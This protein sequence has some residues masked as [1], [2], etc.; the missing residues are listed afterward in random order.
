M[1]TTIKR[2]GPALGLLLAA[3]MAPPAAAEPALQV[4]LWPESPAPGIAFRVLARGEWPSGC[5]PPV[6]DSWV[7]GREIVL[8]LRPTPKDCAKGP[9]LP[10]EIYN[11]AAGESRL[12]V[13]QEGVYRLRVIG[14]E[15]ERTLAFALAQIGDSPRDPRPETGLWWPEQAGEFAEGG[16]GLGA[17]VEVQGQQVAITA[18]GYEG[19]GQPSWWIGASRL[20]GAL[21]RLALSHLKG[22]AGPFQRYRRP[23]AVEPVGSLFVEWL[24]SARAVFWFVAEGDG[25]QGLQVQPISMVRFSFG[26]RPGR[27]WLGDWVRIERDGDG[28]GS[29][30][31]LQFVDHRGHAEGFVLTASDRSELHCQSDG[32]RTDSPPTLCVLLEGDPVGGSS[33]F[34]DI[35]LGVLRSTPQGGRQVELRRLD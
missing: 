24:S 17:L 35:A 34:D 13:E 9:S 15:P 6:G 32:L 31:L 29:S 3:L 33:E 26:L 23:E 7:D 1:L 10:A 25:Q 11:A 21:S 19:S 18:T 8:Q 20:E 16:P 2:T 22:G 14:A 4:Q 30:R 5:V 27:E 28:A 12:Q